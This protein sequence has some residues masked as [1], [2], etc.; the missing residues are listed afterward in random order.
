MTKYKQIKVGL[1]IFAANFGS[2]DSCNKSNSKD[3]LLMHHQN[4]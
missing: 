1:F 2:F 3:V 4:V